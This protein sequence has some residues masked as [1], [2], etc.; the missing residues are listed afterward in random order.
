MSFEFYNKKYGLDMLG[1]IDSAYSKKDYWV[2]N[3]CQGKFKTREEAFS[4]HTYETFLSFVNN[5][6]NSN[7]LIYIEG[8]KDVTGGWLSVVLDSKDRLGVHKAKKYFLET[9]DIS[10]RENND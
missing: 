9:M 5:K 7:N 2:C 3:W 4:S 8:P 10:R 1:D 6:L